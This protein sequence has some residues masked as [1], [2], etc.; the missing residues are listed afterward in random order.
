MDNQEDEL[1]LVSH[2]YIEIGIQYDK[3]YIH[4]EDTGSTC[5]TTPG[6]TCIRLT[7]EETD[8]LIRGLQRAR[9]VLVNES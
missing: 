5:Y 8:W 7:K 3:I 2:D 9:E 6:I 1:H 4:A